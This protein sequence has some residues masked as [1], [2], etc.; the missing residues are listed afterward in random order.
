[1]KISKKLVLISMLSLSSGVAWAA[2]VETLD[3]STDASAFIGERVEDD[4]VNAGQSSL[5]S[6]VGTPAETG[7]FSGLSGL[8]D[9][10][11]NSQ[12]ENPQGKTYYEPTLLPGTVTFEL[13]ITV[14]AFGYDITDI[15]TFAGW[16]GNSSTLANQQY[17]ILVS[18]V[19]SAGFTSLTTVDYTPFSS[20]ASGGTK[21]FLSDSLPSGKLAAGVD[22]IRFVFADDGAGFG[23]VYHEVD[24]IGVAAIPEPG[25]ISL[26]SISTIGL[27]LT[28]RIRRRRHLGMSI[29]PVRKARACDVFSETDDLYDTDAEAESVFT[30]VVLPSLIGCATS[31]K[32]AFSKVDRNFWNYVVSVHENRVQRRVAFRA[33]LEAK[34]QNNLES[35]PG[36]IRYAASVKSA[37]SAVDRNLWNH[38]VSVHERRVQRRIA[39]RAALKAK[40][41]NNLD[42][43]LAKIIK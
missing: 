26:M 1:M 14:N 9:G 17:E 8:N 38:M 24:V 25:T 5:D 31:V 16:G 36:L 23:T 21:V 10:F 40:L 32:D 27:F 22:A 7:F 34:S 37:F 18:A 11:I 41:L 29:V 15:N 28:R 12:T 42:S 20:G 33:A 6:V 19:G 43:F 4:L 30:E 2:I 13:D 35:L 39:F 3:S